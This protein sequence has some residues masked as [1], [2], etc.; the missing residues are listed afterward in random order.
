MDLA[1]SGN[2]VVGID[3]RHPWELARLEVIK[4]VL[5]DLPELRAGDVVLDVGCGDSFVVDQIASSYPGVSFYGIDAAFDEQ[6]L[7][8]FTR[9]RQV[10]NVRLFRTLEEAAPDIGE[11]KAALILL[12]DVIEHIEDEVAFLKHLRAS[13]LVGPATRYIISVPAFGFLFST[14]DVRLGHYRRYSNRTLERRLNEAGLEPQL[15]CYFFSSLLL[16]R[17]AQAGVEKLLR[18]GAGSGTQVAQWRGGKARQTVI[19][20]M[21]VWDF[22]LSHALYR[23]GIKLPGLSNL[24]VCTAPA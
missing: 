17:L 16:P 21:L 19:T 12:M 14:H 4:R 2:R 15:I 23:M 24:A 3:K 20:S 7:R 22:R 9:K 11:K 13:P 8:T 1:E 10:N 18:V 5:R 6:L